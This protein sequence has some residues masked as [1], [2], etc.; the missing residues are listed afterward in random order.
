MKKHQPDQPR[1][2]GDYEDCDQSVYD[3]LIKVLRFEEFSDFRELNYKLIFSHKTKISKGRRV[4]ATI[5]LRKEKDTL[6]HPYEALIYID[7]VYW[8]MN[9]DKREPL[10]Y[11]ELCHLYYDDET[12]KMSLVGHDV[13][14][15]YAVVRRYGDWQKDLEKFNMA[16]QQ[17]RLNLNYNQP[18]G[19]LENFR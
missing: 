8:M 3:V 11:H 14:D 12:E 5:S 10:L 2:I 15:F 6:V 9:E 18:D 1:H 4:L 13:E 7:G 16:A 17:L 19:L